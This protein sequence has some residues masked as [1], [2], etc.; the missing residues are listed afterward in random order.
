MGALEG[1]CERTRKMAEGLVFVNLKRKSAFYVYVTT[2]RQIMS[3]ED[4]RTLREECILYRAKQSAQMHQ[5]L[6]EMAL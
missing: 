3:Y 4:I 1:K 5:N 6:Q 2:G